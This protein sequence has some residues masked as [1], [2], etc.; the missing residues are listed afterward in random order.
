MYICSKSDDAIVYGAFDADFLQRE[1]GDIG[2]FEFSADHYRC[3]NCHDDR[4]FVR[5][6]GTH[7]CAIGH[8]RFFPTK[9]FVEKS[10]QRYRHPSFAIAACARAP[11]ADSVSAGVAVH[12]LFPNH[13]RTN[14]CKW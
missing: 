2:V 7:L 6:D 13:T 12:G 9:Y 5:Y 8:S 11:S 1:T 4:N 10:A 3:C 14:N